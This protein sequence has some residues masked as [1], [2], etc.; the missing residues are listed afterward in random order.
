MKTNG[1]CSLC[2]S[3][4]IGN[5]FDSNNFSILFCNSCQNYFTQPFPRVPEYENLDFHANERSDQFQQLKYVN[6]LPDDWQRLIRFQVRLLVDKLKKDS[7]IL[8]IGCGEGLLLYELGEQGFSNLE[9]IEPSKSAFARGT[10]KGLVIY[11]DYLENLSLL[12]QYDVIIM[13]HVLE[14]VEDPITYIKTLKK[15]LRPNGYLLL[16]QTNCEGWIPKLLGPGWYAWVPEQHFWHFTERG[17]TKILNPMG[18]EVRSVEYTSLVH[19]H[20]FLYWTTRIFKKSQDQ[21]IILFQQQNLSVEQQH[22]GS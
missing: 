5:T 2:R 7:N 1:T 6:D 12:N 9:G 11:N 22:L 4:E 13:S 8:E 10:K 17:L 3:T 15:Y 14:H 21:F 20:N 18:F 19:A 16:T